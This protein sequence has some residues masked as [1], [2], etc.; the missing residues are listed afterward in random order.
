MIVI[1]KNPGEKIPY[2]V[3]GTKVTFD[4]ELT[5]NLA[6]LERDWPI[7]R[8]VYY[9]ADGELITGIQAATAL[10]AEIDIPEAQYETTGSED[11]EER[12]KKPIDMDAVTLTLWAID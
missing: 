1:E 2:E 10:V 9:D 4:D 3:H 5:L 12:V 7:H 8:E 6:K 11:E